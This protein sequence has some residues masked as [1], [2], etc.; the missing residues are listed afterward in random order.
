MSSPARP[1]EEDE[2]Q[3]RDGEGGDPQQYSVGVHPRTDRSRPQTGSGPTGA[4]PFDG[5][6]EPRADL[7]GRG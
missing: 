6:V 3:H 2:H 1:V 4:Q 7:Y 5:V